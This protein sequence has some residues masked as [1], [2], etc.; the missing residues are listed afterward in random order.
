[1][2]ENNLHKS[3][4]IKVKTTHVVQQPLSVA[5]S[6]FLII[7]SMNPTAAKLCCGDRDW[8]WLTGDGHDHTGNY[9]F[10][11]ILF[12]KQGAIAHSLTEKN[13]KKHTLTMQS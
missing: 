1:M 2:C 11:K 4:S 13:V 10:S 5:S 8:L 6:S 9:Y 12:Q 3:L 7:T